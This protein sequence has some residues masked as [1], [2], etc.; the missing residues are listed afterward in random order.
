[1]S[2]TLQPQEDK[3]QYRIEVRIITV[4]NR[5]M[6]AIGER[7]K[8]QNFN[9]CIKPLRASARV[10]PFKEKRTMKTI[11]K[12][13]TF[14]HVSEAEMCWSKYLQT[15]LIEWRGRFKLLRPSVDSNSMITV[16]RKIWRWLPG[17]WNQY[18]FIVLPDNKFTRVHCVHVTDH[19]S[20]EL[21]MENG[22]IKLCVPQLHKIV[23][24]VKL[25]CVTNLIRDKKINSQMMVSP[26]SDRLYLSPQI[27]H[28]L[29]L[30]GPLL[31]QDTV[32]KRTR[33]KAF[34]VIF[35]CLA[36]ITDYLDLVDG[37]GS[38]EIIMTRR[39]FVTIL[40]YPAAI[41][42]D[43]GS[44][45]IFHRPVHRLGLLEADQDDASAGGG[46]YDEIL[47]TKKPWKKRTPR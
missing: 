26:A 4:K 5:T 28:I 22:H 32:K 45:T 42:S 40:G 1:M 17:N 37:Y 19:T 2:Q 9:S 12:T 47:P 11:G 10:V 43:G 24:Q 33:L 20:I 36:A 16:E 18:S 41:H 34:G 27:Y 23:R 31:I 8:L 46:V 29:D 6:P 38:K 25:H 13:P 21:T 3:I 15:P 30:F 35:G 39:H 14:P 7:V 44:A